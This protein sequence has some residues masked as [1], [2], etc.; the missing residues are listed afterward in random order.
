MSDLTESNKELISLLTN[1]KY[2]QCV[3]CSHRKTEV[4]KPSKTQIVLD[5]EEE[6][7][8]D[9]CESDTSVNTVIAQGLK[10]YKKIGKKSTRQMGKATALKENTGEK[11]NKPKLAEKTKGIYGTASVPAIPEGTKKMA[12][13]AAMVKRAWLFVGR[14]SLETTAE[15]VQEYLNGE[16][17][18]EMFI[19]EAL[20]NNNESTTKSFKFGMPFSL[21]EEALKPTHWPE[22]IL[23]KRFNFFRPR[24]GPGNFRP[25]DHSNNSE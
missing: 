24:R 10:N 7:Y 18:N 11:T 12:T 14:A 5:S 20:S 21:L 6:E 16:F 2:L 13:F 22:G 4:T 17:P 19:V 23:I 25:K 3:K 15:S 1:G 9:T 8:N